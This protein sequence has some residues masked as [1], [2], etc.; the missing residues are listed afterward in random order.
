MDSQ[1]WADTHCAASWQFDANARIAWRRARA[2]SLLDDKQRFS[3]RHGCGFKYVVHCH[4]GIEFLSA[5][6]VISAPGCSD[7]QALSSKILFSFTPGPETHSLLLLR[8]AGMLAL[9]CWAAPTPPMPGES[10]AHEESG[11]PPMSTVSLLWLSRL[12]DLLME[13]VLPTLR[14][15]AASWCT[16]VGHG[17]SAQIRFRATGRRSGA[18][19]KR[20]VSSVQIAARLGE[21]I[22]REMHADGWRETSGI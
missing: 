14:A 3:Q 7:V 1:L 11:P 12:E 8:S 13:H 19:S 16:N 6:E 9:L 5:E 10:G 17:P 22:A 2:K 15:V 21:V 4:T 20:C 18:R